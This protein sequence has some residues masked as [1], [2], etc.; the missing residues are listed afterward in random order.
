M[1]F[2]FWDHGTRVL[3]LLH[4]SLYAYPWNHLHSLLPIVWEQALRCP[5][6]D[7]PQQDILEASRLTGP[8]QFGSV[9]RGNSCL[10]VTPLADS[11]RS[12]SPPCW[13]SSPCSSSQQPCSLE[14]ETRTLMVHLSPDGRVC[15]KLPRPLW[16]TLTHSRKQ[17][18]PPSARVEFTFALPA[19]HR[20]SSCRYLSVRSRLVSLGKFASELRNLALRYLDVHAVRLISSAS[21]SDFSNCCAGPAAW[22]SGSTQSTLGCISTVS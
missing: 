17:T 8:L 18:L 11:R 20:C 14:I 16:R 4:R 9:L 10:H 6:G 12:S 2:L 19:Q 5:V 1:L 21:C 3:L 15:R 7:D 13:K 22:R